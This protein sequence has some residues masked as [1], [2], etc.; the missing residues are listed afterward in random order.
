MTK[1][2]E[3]YNTGWRIEFEKISKVI[4][5]KLN[6]LKIDIQHVGST[7][8]PD[9]FAKPILDIDIIIDDKNS[10]KEITLRLEKLGYK[11]KGEK[12]VNGRFAFRQISDTTPSTNPQR[13]WQSHHL[14]VCYSDSLALKN[15]LLFRDALRM[16]IT[17][18]ERY[19]KLK[20]SLTDNREITREE[21][22]TRK[23]NFIISVLA[24]AGLNQAELKEILNANL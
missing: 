2:I 8:V 19:S 3:P 18:V 9:L 24:D 21:Y 13:K 10:L 11:S 22:S 23:T 16:D 1:L 7:S 5:D 6:D 12:G 4:E 20:K 17:L 15:H 14:Y